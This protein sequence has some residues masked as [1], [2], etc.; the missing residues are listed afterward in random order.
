MKLTPN[1]SL[2][3]LTASETAARKGW[4]NLP[5]DQELQN[6]VR[7]AL[8]LE[9]VR[10][11]LKKPIIVNSGFRS[12]LV[13]DAVGSRDTSQHR[14]G[15]AADIRVPGM[16]PREVCQ[17]IIASGIQYDQLI[18]EFWEE[19]KPGGWTHISVPNTPDGKHRKSTL[20][21]DSKGT[22]MFS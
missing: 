9:Q 13:N 12:K 8:L 6:L 1:F 19:G 14:L 11:V 10:E 2:S 15:C 16:N 17:A 22:R 18:Q 21:I 4:S 3:E 5:N 7:V 20:I